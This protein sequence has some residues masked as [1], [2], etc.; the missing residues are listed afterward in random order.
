MLYITNK[1]VPGFIGAMGNALA[2]NQI[3]IAQLHL[4]RQAEGGDAVALVAVDGPPT[5]EAIAGINALPQVIQ[6]SSLQF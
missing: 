6:L 1:D 5:P 4:G 3:N 2:A